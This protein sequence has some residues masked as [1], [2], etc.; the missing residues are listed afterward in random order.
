MR[1]FC[2]E[3]KVAFFGG[4]KQRKIPVVHDRGNDRNLDDQN[5]G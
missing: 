1:R 4:V 2:A 3:D 5:G